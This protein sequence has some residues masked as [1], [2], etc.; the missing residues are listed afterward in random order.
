MSNLNAQAE[1][2]VASLIESD[3][4]QLYEQLGIRSRAIEQNPAVA[5]SFDPLVTFDAAA[6][7]PIEDVRNL[8]KRI[9]RRWENE[10]FGLAC[11]KRP[12]EAADRKA[13][14]E[15]FGIGVTTVAALITT[16]LVNAFGLAPAIAAVIAAIIVKRFFRPA[17]QEFCEFWGERLSAEASS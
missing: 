8:G 11:G 13:I 9:F 16:A 10:A 15:A 3:E 12:D 6:M 2:A 17:Y 5:G 1:A 4:S 7:G 14:G